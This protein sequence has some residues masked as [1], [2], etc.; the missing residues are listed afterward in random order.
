V[1]LCCC[2]EDFTPS[3]AIQDMCADARSLRFICKG[4]L[5]SAMVR[6]RTVQTHRL[7]YGIAL[8]QYRPFYWMLATADSVHLTYSQLMHLK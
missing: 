7:Q 5:L 3:K 8:Y 1:A 6:Y 2:E 4:L